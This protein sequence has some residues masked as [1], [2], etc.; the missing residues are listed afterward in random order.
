MLIPVLL[1][2][3]VQVP[4]AA[5][6]DTVRPRHDAVHYDIG[7]RL[8]DSTARIAMSVETRWRLTSREPIR[9]DLDSAFHVTVVT[10]NGKPATW[11]RP[12]NRV[13]IPSGGKAGDT[14]VTR[15]NYDGTPRDGLVIGVNAYGARTVFADNWPD[16]AHHWLASQDMPGDKATADLHIEAGAAYQALANGVLLG[17]DTLPGARLRWNFR[18]AEPVPVYTM[19]IAVGKFATTVLPAAACAVKCVPL[20]IVTYPQDSAFAIDGPFRRAGE[21][22]DLFSGLIG[23]FPYE[24]LSHVESSTIF[25][26]MENATAIF[27]DEKGYE[28]RTMQEGVVAHETAHQW[29]GDAV[30]EDDWHHV[31]LSEG[32]AT[33]GGALWSEHT[34]G[35]I[36]RAADMKH[37]ADE[38]FASPATERPILD[39][40]ATRLMGMLNTNSYP[41]GAWVLHSLRGLMGDSAFFAG[42]ARTIGVTG[43]VPC[44]RRISRE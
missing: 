3:Q 20:S 7:I 10:V 4:L 16:R 2:L 21:I 14:I 29:F 6:A 44:S 36:A 34:G 28:K 38:V 13:L 22:V 1:A 18:I 43:T 32:F 40:Q 9:I 37:N 11:E 33:Y 24:R 35:V 12:A 19:V 42:C 8:G 39:L 15:V 17:V 26:G 25:G 31:W 30:T 27:Y 23:P 41:K 5:R